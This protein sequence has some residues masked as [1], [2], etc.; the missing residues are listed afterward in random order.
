LGLLPLVRAAEITVTVTVPDEVL[1]GVRQFY[2]LTPGTPADEARLQAVAQSILQQTFTQAA[3]T[4]VERLGTT[5][6][7]LWWQAPA[8]GRTPVRAD[9]QRALEKAVE[10]YRL[11]PTPPPP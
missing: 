8:Q 2:S 9:I 6:A 11:P 4:Y 7:D 3:Q 1:L 10:A 5:L